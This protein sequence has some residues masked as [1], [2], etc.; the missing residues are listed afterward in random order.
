MVLATSCR[1]D[2]AYWHETDL[3]PLVRHVRCRWMNRPSKDAAQGL[4]LTRNGHAQRLLDKL[5][6]ADADLVPGT[7]IQ[8]ARRNEPAGFFLRGRYISI[9]AALFAGAAPSI[10]PICFIS[11][12]ISK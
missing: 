11:V 6:G 1:C 4:S 10:A 2:V 9:Y 7:A 8:A 12:S 5:A 3:L